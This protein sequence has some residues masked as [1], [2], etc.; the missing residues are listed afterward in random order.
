[1]KKPREKRAGVEDEAAG[2]AF[3]ALVLEVFR[4]NGRL[5]A[6]GNQLGDGLDLTAT[7]WQVLGAVALSQG[8]ATVAEI[9]RLMG[10]TRQGVQRVVDDLEAAG[11]VRRVAHASNLRARPVELTEAGVARYAAITRRQV[12]WAIRCAEGFPPAELDALVARLRTIGQRVDEVSDQ[13]TGATGKR[14]DG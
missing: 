6:A 3:T 2:A 4:L 1:M 9:G 8:A 11:L 10:M 5:L 14:K 12:P 7:R 13:P